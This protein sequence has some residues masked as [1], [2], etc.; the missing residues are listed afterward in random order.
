MNLR[1]L[2]LKEEKSDEQRFQDLQPPL[3]KKLEEQRIFHNNPK[4]DPNILIDIEALV[5]FRDYSLREIEEFYSFEIRKDDEQAETEY[6]KLTEH[7]HKIIKR[8]IE[9]HNAYRQFNNYQET[10]DFNQNRTNNYLK[11]WR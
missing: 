4:I 5:L 8:A 2:P 10:V 3:N 11:T 7:Q 9:L 1:T 6:D